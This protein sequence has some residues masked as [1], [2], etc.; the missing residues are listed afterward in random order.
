MGVQSTKQF[1][2]G[3]CSQGT[4]S[5][6][7]QADLRMTNTLRQPDHENLRHPVSSYK[8]ESYASEGALPCE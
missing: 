5:F 7:A 8:Y 3:N 4:E 1:F 2:D 6:R